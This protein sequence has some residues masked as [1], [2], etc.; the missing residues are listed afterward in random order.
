MK[1][2]HTTALV[3]PRGGLLCVL[4]ALLAVLNILLKSVELLS[5]EVVAL[6]DYS[7]PHVLVNSPQKLPASTLCDE[8]RLYI[9]ETRMQIVTEWGYPVLSTAM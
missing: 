5:S 3:L 8:S 9:N 6:S 2:A 7:R 1:A 4:L